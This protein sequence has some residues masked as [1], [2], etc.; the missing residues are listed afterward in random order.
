MP[1]REYARSGVDTGEAD[2]A[3]ARLLL[4]VSPTQAFGA[5]SEVGV[6]HFAAVIRVGPVQ[7]ALTTDGVGTKLLVAQACGRY[8][9][10]GID[11]IGMNVNDLICVGARPVA[12]LDY[13]AIERAD[14][15][16]F[17]EVG[18]G[19]AE[20]ARQA[21]ISIV[22]GETAQVPEMLRGATTGRGLDLVGMAVGVVE[23]GEL[24][25]GSAARP[26]DVVIGL[27]ANGLHSNGYTLARHVL[28][29]KLALDAHVPELGGT[30][31]DELLRPVRIYV[32]QLRALR[33]AGVRPHAI[34]HITGDGLLNLRRLEAP[35]GFEIDHLPPAP[36]IFELIEQLGQISRAEMRTVFNMGVGL[37]VVVDGADAETALTTLDQSGVEAWPIGRLVADPERRVRL[38][39]EK[40]VGQA[41]QFLP[42]GG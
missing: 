8:D 20:G 21:G 9:S 29:P 2:R 12:M 41:K 7:L 13:L 31:G 23:E 36:P 5:P 33:E 18:R 38:L 1:G 10:I 30:L 39:P 16:V 40:L 3:L 28:L 35:V 42:D 32:A 24:V 34:A 37:T 4:E 15:E 27:A 6:G 19:L 26:G 17:A 25:D 14:P 22:G 11:C